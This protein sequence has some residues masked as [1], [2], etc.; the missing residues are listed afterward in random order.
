MA[1]A[2][3]V[4]PASGQHTATVIFLHGLGDTGHGWSPVFQDMIREP[5]IK[6][7]CPHAQTR[8]VTLNM[9]MKMPA[10]F[11]IFGLTIQSKEDEK[12]IEESA[13]KIREMMDAEVKNG[14][15]S[16]RIMIGGFSMGGALALYS[17]FTYD[18]PLA[19]VIALSSFLVQRNKLPGNHTANKEVPVF[20]AHGDADPLC[21]LTFG[22]ATA[23]LIK[24]FNPNL[25]FK[26][27]N[28][29]GHSACDQEF[30][31][32]R[33]FIAKRLPPK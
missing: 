14:I 15:P 19:G 13:V 5:H 23:Q 28:G 6:Y 18:K 31:D 16:D 30:K 26:I 2:P 3:V 24:V 22:Q 9:G 25:E 21:D 4:I 17:A 1:S 10:W 8:A 32:V 29:M 20:Q 33:A 12:G 27:Y 11:D 7:I